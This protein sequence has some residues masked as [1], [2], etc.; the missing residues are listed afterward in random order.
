MSFDV[1]STWIVLPPRQV[2]AHLPSSLRL[3]VR[4][5]LSREVPPTPLTPPWPPASHLSPLGSFS[6]QSSSHCPVAR[7]SVGL[8][9]LEDTLLEGRTSFCSWLW[10]QP[11]EEQ[12]LL[13]CCSGGITAPSQARVTPILT[14]T[15]CQKTKANPSSPIQLLSHL[16]FFTDNLLERLL[17][18]CSM[19]SAMVHP[20]TWNPAQLGI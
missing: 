17:H 11:L 14:Q 9:I 15:N 5:H 12:A 2:P 18:T 3:L 6:P 16:P 20:S 8:F 7:P 19:D 1:H 10:P 4:C 13:T